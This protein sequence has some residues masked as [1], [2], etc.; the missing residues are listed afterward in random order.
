MFST[1]SAPTPSSSSRSK[2]SPIIPIPRRIFKLGTTVTALFAAAETPEPF[3]L[4]AIPEA[5]LD[6]G[7]DTLEDVLSEIELDSE[8]GVS[9]DSDSDPGSLRDGAS[10][11]GVSSDYHLRSLLNSGGPIVELNPAKI[12]N[13]RSPSTRG[14]RSMCPAGDRKAVCG[15][16]NRNEER[17]LEDLKRINKGSSHKRGGR[18]SNLVSVR[19]GSPE[20]NYDYRPYFNWFEE[21]RSITEAPSESKN[22]LHSELRTRL[23][24]DLL[25]SDPASSRISSLSPKKEKPNRPFRL[26]QSNVITKD[27]APVLT[28]QALINAMKPPFP[29]MEEMYARYT[30]SYSPSSERR[31]YIAPEGQNETKTSTTGTGTGTNRTISLPLQPIESQ[32]KLT[33]LRIPV[34]F[35]DLAQPCKNVITNHVM[36][37]DAIPAGFCKDF[38]MLNPFHME[39]P[40]NCRKYQC[41]MWVM[42]LGDLVGSNPADSEPAPCRPYVCYLAQFMNS[43]G[44]LRGYEDPVSYQDQHCGPRFLRDALTICDWGY[45]GCA[46]WGGMNKRIADEATAGRYDSLAYPIVSNPG[47]TTPT[48]TSPVASLLNPLNHPIPYPMGTPLFRSQLPLYADLIL[49]GNLD[50][51]DLD[52]RGEWQLLGWTTQTWASRRFGLRQSGLTGGPQNPSDNLVYASNA[53]ES[54]I[55]NQYAF[56][57]SSELKC[58]DQLTE[59]ERDAVRKLQITI[60]GWHLCGDIPGLRDHCDWP[61]FLSTDGVYP[62]SHRLYDCMSTRK[63]V[64]EPLHQVYGKSRWDHTDGDMGFMTQQK[65]EA[66]GDLGYLTAKAWD[67]RVSR[68]LNLY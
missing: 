44:G 60:D 35:A 3:T 57:P 49:R 68:I 48:S 50:N 45:R 20:E 17:L 8:G 29:E 65:K 53:T 37:T 54:Q 52:L 12:E 30:T 56:L 2:F 62:S 28:G 61:H 26:L 32:L 34:D 63:R 18:L 43:N 25:E 1:T 47:S 23:G 13:A 4:D 66:Y 5:G 14:I 10:V 19:P 6:S 31:L 15:T 59:V 21:S 27:Q 7:I 9:S 33:D 41:S 46:S 55:K 11:K 16:S 58:Y 67:E 38:V 36:Y 40:I 39:M 42:M 22:D 64:E 51:L 24:L